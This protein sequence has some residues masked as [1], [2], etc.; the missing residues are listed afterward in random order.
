MRSDAAPALA[1]TAVTPASYTY[2][3]FT[4]DANGRLTAASSGTP[5]TTY[6][7]GAGLTLTGAAFSETIPLLYGVGPDTTSYAIG[8]GLQG[9]SYSG[10]I[11]LAIGTTALLNNTTGLGNLAI[12][13][14]SLSLNTTGNFN[15]AI[16][17]SALASNISASYSFALGFSA[18]S[19][20]TGLGNTAI[21]FEAGYSL[22]T[23]TVNC[24]I[25]FEVAHGTLQSGSGNIL[26]GFELDTPANNT[27]SYLNIGGSII[28]ATVG[29]GPILYL[30]NFTV[31]TLPASPTAGSRAMVTDALAATFGAAPTGG[32]STYAPVF[33]NGAA[34][35]MG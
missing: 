35:I 3:S 34:W 15:T 1:T 21:G 5:P 32:H 17:V 9:G 14:G 33:Y 11:N 8:G 20:A 25:G 24:L 31:A 27:S 13:D 4:V 29:Y 30:D 18:L 19:S 28:S 2:G 7:A 16:G 10:S 6:T 26:I 23:G 12:G 22:T